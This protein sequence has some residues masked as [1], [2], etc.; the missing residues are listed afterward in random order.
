MVL[1]PAVQVNTVSTAITIERDSLSDEV[2]HKFASLSFY[3][4]Y[5]QLDLIYQ[6]LLLERGF[7]VP[8]WLEID[9]VRLENKIN[10][11]KLR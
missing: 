5:Y 8:F 2:R 9:L 7:R 10:D 11:Y 6:E 4:S 1:Q 3:T